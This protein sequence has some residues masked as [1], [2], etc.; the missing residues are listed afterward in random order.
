MAWSL[1][2]LIITFIFVFVFGIVSLCGCINL[3]TFPSCGNK[4]LVWFGALIEYGV[5]GLMVGAIA[6]NSWSIAGPDTVFNIYLNFGVFSPYLSSK[7]NRDAPST[8][9]YAKWCS[10]LNG[11][12]SGAVSQ[13]TKNI[14]LTVAMGGMTTF[15]FGCIFILVS[16]LVVVLST[17]TICGKRGLW[18]PKKSSLLQF[19]LGLGIVLS[20]IC[21][22]SALQRLLSILPLN[23]FAAFTP[24]NYGKSWYLSLVSFILSLPLAFLYAQKEIP[25]TTLYQVFTNKDTA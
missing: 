24:W 22:D 7:N 23:P 10:N 13:D 12:P 1:Y 21:A 15:I 17:A 11:L 3:P 16:L 25:E 18:S 2:V 4:W 19:V 14:C 9:T 5:F 6:I 8:E 20:W